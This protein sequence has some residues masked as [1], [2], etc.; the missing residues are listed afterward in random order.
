MENWVASGE[1]K[2]KEHVVEGLDK[3]VATLNGVLEGKHFGKAVLKVS[4]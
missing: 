3:G 2:Y 1:I 4:D